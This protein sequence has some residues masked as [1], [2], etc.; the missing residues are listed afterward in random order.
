MLRSIKYQALRYG[1]PFRKQLK[2][3]QKLLQDQIKIVFA[4]ILYFEKLLFL[5][6]I[7]ILILL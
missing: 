4:T 7:L 1:T 3:L 5:H 6:T 2:N